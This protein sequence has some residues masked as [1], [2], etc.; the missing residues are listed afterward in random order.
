MKHQER[1]KGIPNKV[2][3]DKHDKVGCNSSSDKTRSIR[4]HECQR[5][6]YYRIKCLSCNK[7]L[8]KGKGKTLVV[9]LTD[10]ETYSSE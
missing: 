6:A 5:F 2:L 4:C 9:S 3:K 7:N 1:T 8:N 10:D